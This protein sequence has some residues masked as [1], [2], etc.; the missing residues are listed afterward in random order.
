MSR[1]SNTQNAS[2][3]SAHAHIQSRAQNNGLSA[4]KAARLASYLRQ[5]SGYID[6]HPDLQAA[7]KGAFDV[8]DVYTGTK[9]AIGTAGY[10]GIL[11]AKIISHGASGGASV[12]G[13]F[14]SRFAALA[15]SQGIELNECALT[16]AQV[17]TDIG[18]AGVGA[19]TSVTGWGFLFLAVSVVSTLQDG[20][21]LPKACFS[22]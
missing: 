14:V 16:V 11:N 13:V 2:I 3:S 15:K 12:L 5:M 19:V 20:Y 6:K 9:A 21:S 22:E 18:G 1:E 8:H 10:K 17:A 7:L 4:E